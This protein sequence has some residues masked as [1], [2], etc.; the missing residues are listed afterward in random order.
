MV[1]EICFAYLSPIC[2][3]LHLYLLLLYLKNQF[4]TFMC[5]ARK[6]K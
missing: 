3:L 5:I 4:D 2:L 1:E 6:R